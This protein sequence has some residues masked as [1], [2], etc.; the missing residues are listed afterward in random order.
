MFE[1]LL[2]SC[3]PDGSMSLCNSGKTHAQSCKHG[4][5]AGF[6]PHKQQFVNTLV[7]VLSHKLRINFVNCNDEPEVMFY[8]WDDISKDF[9]T[10]T[11][12]NK[13]KNAL[14]SRPSLDELRLY[15]VQ[16][17]TTC[18]LLDNGGFAGQAANVAAVTKE[19]AD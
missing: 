10:H 9:Y 8:Y 6:I 13:L 14:N 1:H 16:P 18:L 7:S 15:R 11:P 2:A 4:S 17:V 5:F 12:K 3:Q 19:R